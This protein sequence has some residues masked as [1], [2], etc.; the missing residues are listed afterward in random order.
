DS[1][2]A[3]NHIDPSNPKYATGYAAALVQSRRFAEAVTI[4][5]RVLEIDKD[6]YTAH[7]NLAIAL[8]ELKRFAEA[9]PVYEWIAASR[10]DLASTYFYIAIANDKLGEYQQALDSYEKF[11]ARA[12]AK[13]NQ[14]EIEKV[15]LR[16]PRLRD[17]IKQGQG[18]KPKGH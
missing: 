15:N 7:T 11:L 6:D 14:L 2:A 16:L 4:L 5:R 3:A 1:F 17:Q 9:V 13:Q 8:F 10:P 18:V 12:D